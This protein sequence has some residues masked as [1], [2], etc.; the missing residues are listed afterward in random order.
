MARDEYMEQEY[1]DD[2]GHGQWARRPHGREA[3][4][5]RRE[6]RGY[7]A[8]GDR[9]GQPRDD[10]RGDDERERDQRR[11]WDERRPWGRG[12]ERRFGERGRGFEDDRSRDRGGR[13]GAGEFGRQGGDDEW[14][15]GTGR[16]DLDDRGYDEVDFGERGFRRRGFGDRWPDDRGARGF[17]GERTLLWGETAGDWDEGDYDGGRRRHGGVGYGGMREGQRAYEGGPGRSGVGYAGRGPKGYRR[18]DDRIREE[19]CD[20][21]TA[22][23]DIDASE[24][25][26]TVAQCEVT[27]TGTVP[28]RRTKR[29]AEDRADDVSGVKQVHNQ[30]RV[31]SGETT[32]AFG[33]DADSDP[34]QR[35]AVAPGSAT[36]HGR[37]GG[38]AGDDAAS[39]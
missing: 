26:V 28:D 13:F 4:E 17:E 30:L 16:R 2:P 29:A 10:F 1:R 11:W 6:I 22:D 7:G 18:S 14:R 23:R 36:H 5:L 33:S 3:R 31:Q 39:Q 15:W 37:N 24:I 21:L 34:R 12:D 8:S 19:L 9:R 25:E 35:E 32:R 38:G 27:L 20:R